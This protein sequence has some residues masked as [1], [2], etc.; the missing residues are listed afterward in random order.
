MSGAPLTFDAWWV[1]EFGRPP[2][3]ADSIDVIRKAWEASESE[4]VRVLEIRLAEAITERHEA[5]RLAERHEQ[6]R[7]Q[8]ER[9]CDRVR[10]WWLKA[11]A[12]LTPDAQIDAWVRGEPMCPNTRGE[13]CPDF[14]CCNPELMVPATERV[15]FR[16]AS[17]ETRERMLLGFLFEAAS[18]MSDGPVHVAGV[19]TEGKDAD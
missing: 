2:L 4:R 3:P 13:C 1:E 10:G 17:D 9:Q 14:S 7:R 19:E 11:R 16:D 15:A 8:A 6:L 18:E 12:E 5:V